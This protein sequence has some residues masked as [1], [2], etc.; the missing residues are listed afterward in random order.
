MTH[1]VAGRGERTYS[2]EDGSTKD[3]EGRR[4]RNIWS[5]GKM[6]TFSGG[7]CDNGGGH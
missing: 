5:V 2:A 3:K 1:E 7:T 4:K 6:N